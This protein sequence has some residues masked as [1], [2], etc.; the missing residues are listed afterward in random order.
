MGGDSHGL[1]RLRWYWQLA[2]ISLGWNLPNL[3]SIDRRSDF[4]K[5]IGD[6]FREIRPRKLIETGTY[7]GTGTTYV[8][9][10]LLKKL[11]IRDAE[12]YS[13]EV[14]PKRCRQAQAYLAKVK[15][16]EYV[17]ITN[18]LS[19]PRRLLP[20]IDDIA[21]RYVE[22]ISAGAIYVDH[23]DR[24]RALLYFNETNFADVPD[25]LLG[26][27]LARFDF[28]PDFVLLDSAGHLGEIEFK[29]LISRLK[30]VCYIALDDIFHVKHHKNFV[31]I[32]Q[33]SRFVVKISSKEK[34][35][36]CIAK[37]SP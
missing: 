3:A 29:Y 33:D 34:F 28:K 18:G 8:I 15:L 10:S 37:F 5:S 4:A 17:R 6:L 36:F 32:Q 9:T 14:D 7:F 20:S 23:A 24:E 11:S 27:C 22:D 19:I 2:R 12:F 13:I 30:G 16:A 25:D 21:K 26:E 35:G 1:S 31:N